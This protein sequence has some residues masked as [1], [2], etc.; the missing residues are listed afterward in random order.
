MSTTESETPVPSTGD[1]IG[2][3]GIEGPP[4]EPEPEEENGEDE[5]GGDDD[6]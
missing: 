3:P 1:P 4:G 2:E 6:E 5:E